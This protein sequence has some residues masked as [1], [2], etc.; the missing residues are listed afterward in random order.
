M[1]L[2]VWAT[3][4]AETSTDTDRCHL[5]FYRSHSLTVV[6]VISIAKHICIYSYIFLHI[7]VCICIHVYRVY[8]P[9]DIYGYEFLFLFLY[10]PIWHIHTQG[11]RWQE[12][13]QASLDYGQCRINQQQQPAWTVPHLW[14][15]AMETAP[16]L[17]LRPE[18]VGACSGRHVQNT[19]FS[20]KNCSQMAIS[21]SLGLIWAIP[22]ANVQVMRAK[23]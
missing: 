17:K 8:T 19:L 22:K 3:D 9:T 5:C 1:G 20:H 14:S 16:R 11:K 6:F 21:I 15:L 18:R 13:N 4:L 2:C 10:I 12:P 7:L 23:V